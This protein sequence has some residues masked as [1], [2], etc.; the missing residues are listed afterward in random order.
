MM[1]SKAAANT[2][3]EKVEDKVEDKA[4][5]EATDAPEAVDAEAVE[6]E[7]ADA[8]A[9]SDIS[10]GGRRI[11]RRNMLWATGASVLP[12][13][14]LDTALL[15]GVQLKM[16]KELSDLHGV[17]FKANAGKS[18]VASLLGTVL[19]TVL[20]Q[21]VVPNALR[22][23]AMS[24]PVVGTVLAYAA[25]PLI[26]GAFTYAVGKVFQRHFELGGTFLDL[27]V[28]KVEEYFKS[29]FKEGKEKAEADAE[30]PVETPVA[31]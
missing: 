5:A 19:P 24:L 12:F 31:A 30:A 1:T 7:A 21:T 23:I 15:F 9:V 28:K 25:M 2:A 8:D 20:G 11:I 3:E 26:A 22:G 17:E 18:V 29:K 16:L 27:D 13:G 14:V 10:E 4:A 6:A